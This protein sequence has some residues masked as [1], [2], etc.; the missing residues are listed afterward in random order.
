MPFGRPRIHRY[1]KRKDLLRLLWLRFA[2]SDTE[3]RRMLHKLEG[4]LPEPYTICAALG[5]TLQ[6]VRNWAEGRRKPSDAARK[7]VWLVYQSYFHPGRISD[8]QALCLWGAYTPLNKGKRRHIR[9]DGS[10]LAKP[11]DWLGYDI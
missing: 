1:A 11:E 7:L 9:Q 6:S 10:T 4:A 3:F 5:V 2:V 8:L